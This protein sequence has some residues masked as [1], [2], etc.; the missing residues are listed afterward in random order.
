MEYDKWI[1]LNSD[2]ILDTDG[3]LIPVISPPNATNRKVT[4]TSSD[5][6]MLWLTKLEELLEK[7]RER[8]LLR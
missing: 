2:M 7:D 8:Q 1:N 5:E 4:W 3:Q 6:S